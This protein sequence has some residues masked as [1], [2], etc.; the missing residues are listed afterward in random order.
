M[1]T[2][3]QV[4]PHEYL[5]LQLKLPTKDVLVLDDANAG[6]LDQGT[7]GGE[8]EDTFLFVLDESRL[9][10]KSLSAP[11]DDPDTQWTD[12]AQFVKSISIHRG[13]KETEV[14]SELEVG[15]LNIV[16]I[17]PEVDPHQNLSVD[18][19][20]K[21][22]LITS[23]DDSVFTGIIRRV[24]TTYDR[25]GNVRVNLTVQDTVRELA[26]IPRAGVSLEPFDDRV[27]SLLI[28]TGL[29]YVV[30]GGTKTLAD[31]PYTDNL[32]KHLQLA[33]T[34]EEGY[35]YVDRYGTVQVGGKD[36]FFDPYDRVVLRENE[37]PNAGMRLSA[38]GWGP[39]QGTDSSAYVFDYLQGQGRGQTG[40]IR[41]TFTKTYAGKWGGFTTV[42]YPTWTGTITPGAQYTLSAYVRSNRID[43]PVALEVIYFGE[44]SHFMAIGYEYGVESSMDN[45]TDWK[46][47]SLTFTAPADAVEYGIRLVPAL[48]SPNWIAGDFILLSSVLMEKTDTPKE[49]FD[50][51]TPDENPIFYKWAGE[52]ILS[53]S[54]QIQVTE[55]P[56]AI[57]ITFWGKAVDEPNPYYYRDIEYEKDTS[58]ILN[59]LEIENKA[60]LENSRY[61]YEEATSLFT[62]GAASASIETNLPTPGEVD[63]LGEALIAA[64]AYPVNTVKSL[65]FNATG[66]MAMAAGL[67]PYQL[68]RV[69]FE[70][71]YFEEI[72]M[73]VI[74]GIEHDIVRDKWMTTLT[75]TRY[76][77]GL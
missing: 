66:D 50:G 1:T 43:I 9:D 64:N 14:G 3:Q 54:Q 74:L 59:Q 11:G 44:E 60:G 73:Y 19:G 69:H 65:T 40:A 62:F 31:T 21:A 49:F 29:P 13:A 45:S 63:V 5:R 48:T 52:S 42:N 41:K 61:A 12:M 6:L 68:I 25:E 10:E 4:L 57:G 39:I 16:L 34:S 36:A 75:L 58:T 35:F 33:V 27:D 51:D 26:N 76:K 23:D 30:R 8:F 46:R 47:I 20:T 2:H 53:T 77:G 15:T 72:D 71:N 7:L 22:R 37:A 17:G 55:K 38:G 28:N 56:D 18:V 70:N 67:E 24:K 32:V